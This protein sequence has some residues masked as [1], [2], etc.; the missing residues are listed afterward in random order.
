MLAGRLVG[1]TPEESPM[2]DPFPCSLVVLAVSGTTTGP[3]ARVSSFF[4]RRWG[5][6]WIAWLLLAGFGRGRSLR[7]DRYQLFE[8]VL[9]ADV[10][11]AGHIERVGASTFELRVAEAIVGDEL[12]GRLR[13]QRFEDWTCASRWTEYRPGQRVL[14]FLE[15][16]GSAAAN[17][18]ILGGGGE[19][20]MPLTGPD[21]IVRGYRVRG[22]EAGEH[23]VDGIDVEGAR[24]DLGELAA[25]VRGFRSAF[26]WEDGTLPRENPVL[27][28]QP[29]DPELARSFERSSRTALHLCEQARSSPAWTGPVGDEGDLFPPERFRR[30][31]A[32]ELECTGAVRLAGR[33]PD[34][35]GFELWSGFGSA[36]AF[37]GDVDGDGVGDLAVGAASDSHVG[38]FCGTLW[39]LFLDRAGTVKRKTEIG[40]RSG[41]FPALLNEF[42]SLGEALA[43]LGDLNGDGVPDL[44]VGAAGWDG[45]AERSGGVWILFLGRDGTAVSSVELGSSESLRRAGVGEGY[46]IGWALACLGD[47]D[48]DG[49]PEL[50]IGQD[51]QFDL[52]C[53][54][55]RGV[56]MVSLAR[57]GGVRWVRRLHDREDGFAGRHSWFGAAL[58]R[59]GDLDGNGTSELAIA[60]TY[61]DDGGECRGA[62]W[63]AFLG[64]DGSL[65]RRQKISDW[66]GGF[67][68]LLRGGESFGAALAGPGDLDG[69]AVSDLLVGS[70]SGLWTLFLNRDGTVRGHHLVRNPTRA[71]GQRTAFAR[72]LACSGMR[73]RGSGA[74]L[75]VGGVLG[76][77]RQETRDALVWFFSV[78]EGARLSP[79]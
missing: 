38:H 35:F 1:L 5:V 19:G 71:L 47:L 32:Q 13:V 8:L 41:G 79:W 77:P 24:V 53:K 51:P 50:A 23:A 57:D 42:A 49:L 74:F 31:S 60:D 72:S 59:V 6:M 26:V 4:L 73:A 9:C 18:Q 69:D 34:E 43:P 46:G 3:R 21:V 66:A 78:G 48:G 44:A 55:G 33:T 65:R 10:V 37:P 45:R 67:D 40:E 25:A 22:Y 52:G 68:G 64:P 11:V 15:E 28:I 20:E 17:H 62:V 16:L 30:I 7:Y 56:L 61:D 76:E 58:V 70:A 54:E 63:I 27:T 12:P 14:L 39:L 29:R 2:N 75:A 36:L